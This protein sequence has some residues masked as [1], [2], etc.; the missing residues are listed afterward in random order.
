MTSTEAPTS[1]LLDTNQD[2]TLGGDEIAAQMAEED[3]KNLG[4]RGTFGKPIHSIMKALGIPELSKQY[5]TLF[6]QAL[7]RPDRDKLIE[8]LNQQASVMIEERLKLA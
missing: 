4:S 5:A 1:P 6:Q 8:G 2:G 7:L 3:K